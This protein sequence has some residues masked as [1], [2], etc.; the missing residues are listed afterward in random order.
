MTTT[1]KTPCSNCGIPTLT[2][3]WGNCKT[4]GCDKNAPKAP[5]GCAITPP[6]GTSADEIARRARDLAALDVDPRTSG[7]A[8][9]PTWLVRRVLGSVRP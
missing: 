8:P 2:D 7:S 4:C 9:R 1:K 6:A 3:K 5:T